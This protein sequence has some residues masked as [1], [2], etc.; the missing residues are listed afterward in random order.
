MTGRLHT[1]AEAAEQLRCKESWLKEQARLRRIPFSRVGG[2]YRFS[3]DH[4]EQIILIFEERPDPE[5]R[6][7]AAR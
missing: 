1:P 6:T 2:A 3:D 4:L 5:R 7:A